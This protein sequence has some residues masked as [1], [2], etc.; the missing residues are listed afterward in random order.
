MNLAWTSTTLA[1][2]TGMVLSYWVGMMI[3]GDT[4]SGRGIGGAIVMSILGF[5]MCWTFTFT[6]WWFIDKCSS[7]S[8]CVANEQL[9]EMY[10]RLPYYL[11]PLFA[12]VAAYSAAKYRISSSSS[13]GSF[14]GCGCLDIFDILDCSD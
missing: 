9:G 1:V 8:L 3:P 13:S 14:D 7:L 5:P 4:S 11:I 10:Y 2:M 12:L 6:I